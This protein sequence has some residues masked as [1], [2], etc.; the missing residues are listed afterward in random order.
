MERKNNKIINKNRTVSVKKSVKPKTSSYANKSIRSGF[1]KK[2]V[3]T[4]KVKKNINKNKTNNNKMKQYPNKNKIFN[5]N[6]LAQS[7]NSLGQSQNSF[8][9]SK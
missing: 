3:S 6:N 1:G 2:V 9:I 8:G 5:Q 7:Q 4:K